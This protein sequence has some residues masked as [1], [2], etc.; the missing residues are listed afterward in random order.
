MKNKFPKLD[1][2]KFTCFYLLHV[3]LDFLL[4]CDFTRLVYNSK[5]LLHWRSFAA[6]TNSQKPLNFNNYGIVALGLL[7][8]K[9]DLKLYTLLSKN[10]CYN[11]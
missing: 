6:T 2:P 4:A 3:R 8:K 10:R 9:H 11:S 7:L 5:K 1:L